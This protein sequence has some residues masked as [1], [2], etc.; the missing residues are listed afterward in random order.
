MIWASD[1]DDWRPFCEYKNDCISELTQKLFFGLGPWKEED[2]LFWY[3][4]DSAGFR[5]RRPSWWNSH[6]VCFREGVPWLSLYQ[7]FWSV[8][9]KLK[10]NSRSST[11]CDF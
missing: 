1:W 10:M 5:V 3:L 8:R 7:V 11:T 6:T 4:D 9:V 2:E